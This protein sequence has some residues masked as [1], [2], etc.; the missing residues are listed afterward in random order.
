MAQ[1]QVSDTWSLYVNL[2]EKASPDISR[3]NASLTSVNTRLCSDN[4]S[5]Q[6]IYFQVPFWESIL[7]V[8]IP[9]AENERAEEKVATV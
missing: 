9:E 7:H 5:I 1:V 8:L 6:E 3:E 2:C 4:T